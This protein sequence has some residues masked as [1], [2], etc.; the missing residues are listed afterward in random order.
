MNQLRKAA[1]ILIPLK[2]VFFLFLSLKQSKYCFNL[3]KQKKI[4]RIVNGGWAVFLIMAAV[5]P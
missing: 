1:L 3:L 2:V 5:Q 4:I